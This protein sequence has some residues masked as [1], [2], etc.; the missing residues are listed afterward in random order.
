VG[1]SKLVDATNGV[2]INLSMLMSQP[3]GISNYAK[4]LL[5]FLKPLNPILLIADRH[6]ELSCHLVSSTLTPAQGT[7]GHL[8]RLLWTQSQLPRIYRQQHAQLLFSPIPEAPLFSGCRSVVMVHDL[9]PLHFP[10]RFSPLT[11]YFRYYIPQVLQN[12]LQILCNSVATA[13]DIAQIYGIPAHK[14]VPIPL[15]YDA[16]HFYE[17]ELTRSQH[18]PCFLYIGRPDLYKNLH[19]LISAFA[20][21]PNCHEARLW[22]VGPTDRRFTPRLIAQVRELGLTEQVKFWNYVTHEQLPVLISQATALVF[23]SL[24]EGFGLPILE[25]MA[26]GT[27]VITSNR[28][29]L[30]EVAGDAA[31]LVDPYDVGA[32]AQSMQAVATDPQLW[33]QLRKAGL[34]RATQFSWAKTGQATVEVLQQYL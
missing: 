16:N 8:R 14:I 1:V 31:I 18:F 4:N 28:S 17:R 9:I 5:P 26:C 20:T 11:P 34:A 12:A 21:L 23:P 6:P 22:L 15:A 19:R 13:R 7:Q 2:L 32:I 3:T 27:P 25:A 30:P 29:A 10:R 24:W 33:Q